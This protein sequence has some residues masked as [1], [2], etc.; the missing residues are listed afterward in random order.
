MDSHLSCVNNGGPH[1]IVRLNQVPQLETEVPLQADALKAL[2]LW[3]AQPGEILTVL[4]PE[5]TAYR[6][7]ILSLEPGAACCVPIAYL[8]TSVESPLTVDIYQSVPDLERFELV[9]QQLT[10]VGVSRIVPL[11]SQQTLTLNEKNAPHQNLEPWPEVVSRA[12]RQCR[13]AMIPELLPVHTFSEAL[14]SAVSAEL[15]LMLY[16]GDA[17]WTIKE[18]IGSFNPHSVALLIGPEDG[19][20]QAE[21]EQAQGVGFLPV[22]LGP[23]V[24]RTET[25]AIVA[26]TLL[27]GYLGDLA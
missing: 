8:P 27:Q 14:E 4:D 24:L 22:R 20:S 13:R 15:K 17:S 6:A 25:A 10:E 5:S 9:L 1:S 7:R 23:R 2:S 19:F 26:T 3:Q 16:A 18:G 21:I 11:E 12:S